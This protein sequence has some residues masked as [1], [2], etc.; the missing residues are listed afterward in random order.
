[1]EQPRTMRERRS[2]LED[3]TIEFDGLAIAILALGFAGVSGG[4]FWILSSASQ[5]MDVVV[6]IASAL[7]GLGTIVAWIFGYPRHA[8]I[9]SMSF[10]F[11]LAVAL[12]PYAFALNGALLREAESAPISRVYVAAGLHVGGLGIVALAFLIFGFL[13]PLV[14]AILALRRGV[15][16]AALALRLHIALR[17]RCDPC[18]KQTAITVVIRFFGRFSPRNTLAHSPQLLA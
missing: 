5:S 17:R 18:R 16:G 15:P 11:V 6:W 2:I 1:M 3:R 7:V 10:I 9:P 13:G 4:A 8:A 12:L 14:G